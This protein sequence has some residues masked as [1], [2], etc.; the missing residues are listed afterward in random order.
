MYFESLFAIVSAIMWASS[1]HI[2]NKAFTNNT[3]SIHTVI[4]GL[5]IALLFGTLTLTPFALTTKESVVFNMEIVLAGIFTFPLATFMYYLSGI[6]FKSRAEFAAQFSKVKPLITLLL[7][8]LILEE[9]IIGHSLASS[10]LIAIGVLI[11]LIGTSYKK[12]DFYGVIFGL[13]TALFWAIGEIFEKLGVNDNDPIVS[14]WISLFSSF[15]VFSLIAIPYIL[16]NGFKTSKDIIYWPFA[17]HG[18]ISFGVAYSFFYYSIS[19]IGVSKTILITTFWPVL[20]LFIGFLISLYRK[21]EVNLPKVIIVAS[22][23]FLTA[24]IIQITGL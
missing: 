11:L 9:P 22:L 21:E 8:Y 4:V 6:F 23:L 10:V 16:N 1:A 19:Q 15:I 7:A 13:A 24:S 12:I 17:I 20:S 5:Y 2:L 14:T 18:V 3:F